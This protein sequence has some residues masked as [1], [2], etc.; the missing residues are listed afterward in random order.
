MK[1]ILIVDDDQKDSDS[2]KSILEAK[3][4]E[5]LVENNGA[6]AI[7]AIDESKFD[8]IFIDIKMP[9]LSG[10]DLLRLL[11][12]KVDGTSKMVYVS[13]IPKNEVNMDAVDGFIQKPFSQE[14]L[15]Q[16]TEALI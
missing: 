15:I 4:Y 5:V 11:R 2:M 12:E 1:K 13:I 3:G 7:D 8:L 6:E 10:Y 14:T 9:T 16:K